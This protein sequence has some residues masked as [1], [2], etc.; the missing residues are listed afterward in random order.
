M[1]I[2]SLFITIS[3]VSSS[4]VAPALPFLT[5]KVQIEEEFVSQLIFS[6]CM[7]AYAIGPLFLAPLSEPYG[8]GIFLQLANLFYLVFNIA[9]GVSPRL[10]GN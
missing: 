7:L 5:A 3:P 4:T 8:R 6:V 10:R 1:T 2:V 9:C